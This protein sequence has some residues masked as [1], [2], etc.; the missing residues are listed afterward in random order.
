MATARYR[1]EHDAA[2][3]PSRPGPSRRLLA[4]VVSVL[5]VWLAACGSADEATTDV[6]EN[7]RTIEIVATEYA[8]SGDP[9]TITA[10]ET[11]RFVVRNDGGLIHE[12]QLL[13]TDAR[14]V[15]RTEQLA[16]GEV[17][18]ITVTFA[19][20]GL[21]QVICDVDDHLSR[22]QRASFTVGE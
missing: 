21:Y 4:I 5:T 1:L 22:G 16:P 15:D 10:G 9:T 7:T 17:G 3:F 11:I 18:E 13:D 8:F 2:P 14:L 6:P 20:P 12:L 19:S